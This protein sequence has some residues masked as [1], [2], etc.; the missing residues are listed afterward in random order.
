MF[1]FAF[2]FNFKF[3][4]P[5]LT[6]KTDVL[7]YSNAYHLLRRTTYHITKAKIL[8]F[9]SRTPV[10]ALD[11]LF[12]FSEPFPPTPL[13][14]NN[15]TIVP[16]VANPTITDTLNTAT[17]V[18]FDKYWWLYHAYKDES[19]QYRI[20]MF[21]HILFVADDNYTI[22]S[23]FDYKE[24]LRF[25]ANKSIKDLAIK[26]TTNPRMLVFLNNNVNKKNSPN[27]NY[28]REFLELFTILKGLQVG[29][30]DYTNY[31]ELDVQQAAKVLT[32]FTTSSTVLDKFGRL[33]N[34]DPVTNLPNGIISISNHDTTSVKTFSYAFGGASIN[35]GTTAATIQ[36]ELE[37]FV[38]MIFNQDETAKAYCRR[39]YRYFVGRTI[40][41]EIESG[42]IVPLATLLRANNYSILPTL[43]ALLSSKHFYDEE[44]TVKGDQVIGSLA[45]NSM[46]LYF[47]MMSLLGVQIPLYENNAASI[48]N[49]MKNKMYA[50]VT[51]A[52]FPFFAPQSVNGY[53][54]FSSSPDYDKNWIT[55]ASLRIRYLN[56]IDLFI[57]GFTYNSFLYKLNLPAFVKDSGN[58]AN[59]QI[60]DN[61]VT[62][63]FNL[64]HIEVP[65]TVR[66]NYFKD[67]FLGGL[68]AINWLNE[69]NNYLNTGVSTNVKIPIDNLVK[70]LIKS[71]EFQTF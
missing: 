32:G 56:T 23:N 65:S 16:T 4:M 10:E 37:D 63:F 68:S 3:K 26:V 40:S 13:N 41:P 14:T 6:Q 47:H 36:A 52:G 53:A 17:T 27:Q 39:M 48:H 25:H 55:T 54:G 28:A 45:R 71:P 60:A 20:A 51:N 1:N 34:V 64:L 38:S 50:N 62:D 61:L 69:W 18:L 7:G 66:Y 67:I 21:L 9:A 59:P 31:T 5:S 58:F 42:I 22:H 15:E 44:D 30:G 70:A 43:Q 24:L 29:T 33:Q 11:I 2:K 19:A 12:N 8:D 57:S 46:E 35:P 49:L